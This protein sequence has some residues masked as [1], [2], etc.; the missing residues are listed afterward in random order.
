MP[1]DTFGLKIEP[2]QPSEE[3]AEET[4]LDDGEST[5]D[6][7]ADDPADNEEPADDDLGDDPEG[8]EDGEPIEFKEWGKQYD[9]SEDITS[10]DDLA[11][12]Y[13]ALL[14]GQPTEMSAEMQQIDA[15]LKAKG[16]GGIEA[17]KTGTPPVK[18]PE[19]KQPESSSF[20]QDNAFMG[21]VDLM[22]KNGMLKEADAE[23]YRSHA[24]FSDQVMNP[25][26][27]K[28]QQV[29][30]AMA[31]SL[32]ETRDGI[33][34]I[35]MSGAARMLKGTDVTTDTIKSFM[36]L[37]NIQDWDKGVTMYSAI[38]DPSLLSKIQSNA[39]E[40]GINKG[41]KKLKRST[42][43]RKHR[44]GTPSADGFNAKKWANADGSLNEDA[45]GQMQDLDARLKV[46]NDYE[47]W[48]KKR[49]A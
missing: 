45:V 28:M 24:R 35:N 27:Q 48:S 30:G 34:R 23:G 16:L 36:R 5:D 47:K 37:H 49:S 1:E 17:L 33:D 3:S 19:Q 42:S 43:K 10:E 8:Q 46:I 9:L 7:D 21:Q 14:K 15:M 41:K 18:E 26:M 40:R 6:Q 31:Q 39:E 25:V 32:F 38:N 11:E 4:P 29:L 12:K 13:Q 2:D 22:V 44:G 20:F